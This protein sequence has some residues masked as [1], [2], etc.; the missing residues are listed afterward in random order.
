MEQ[1]KKKDRNFFLYFEYIGTL[2][3]TVAF[4]MAK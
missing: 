2:G 1:F 3:L 4:N